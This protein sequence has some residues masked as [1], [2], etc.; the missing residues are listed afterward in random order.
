MLCGIVYFFDRIRQVCK[1]ERQDEITMGQAKRSKA[2][3][4]RTKI[5][6]NSLH[7]NKYVLQ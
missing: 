3:A 4:E 1:T 2:Q 6:H 7:I 5:L